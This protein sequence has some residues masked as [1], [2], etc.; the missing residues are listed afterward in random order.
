MTCMQ[1]PALHLCPLKSYK[2]T[3]I[4]PLSVEIVWIPLTPCEIC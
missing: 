4:S 1:S 3:L 2:E